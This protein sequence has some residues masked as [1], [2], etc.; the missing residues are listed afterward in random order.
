MDIKILV[1]A[2]CIILFSLSIFVKIYRPKEK[3]QMKLEASY[4]EG[5]KNYLAAPNQTLKTQIV[6]DGLNYYNNLGLTEENALRTIEKDLK[7]KSN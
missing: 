4:F 1:C 5:L 7:Q 6:N 3:L 2:M